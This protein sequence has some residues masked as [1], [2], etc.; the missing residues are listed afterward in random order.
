MKNKVLGQSLFQWQKDFF[1]LYFQHPKNSIFVIKSGRQ[2]AK[3]HTLQNLIM[4][5]TINNKNH[6]IIVITP[7]YNLCRKFFKDL[8]NVLEP[9]PNLVKSAN[10]SY[11]EI[12]LYN[13]STISLKSVESGNSLRGLN[14]QTLIFDEGAF[15]NLDT[16]LECFNFVNVSQGNI[17]I[18]STPKFRDENTDL[19]AKYWCMAERGEKNVYS[20]DFTTY[21]TR[22]LLSDERKEMYRKQLPKNIYLNE[23]EGQFL[24]N[25][26]ELFNLENVL[27]NGA[28]PDNNM[29]MGVDWS[30]GTNND[31]TAISIFNSSKQMVALHTFNDKDANATIQYIINILK[32]GNI[33]KCI[34][35]TNSI[36]KPMLDFLRKQ[37]SL[38]HIRV[39]IIEFQTTNSSKREIMEQLILEVQNRTITLLENFQLKNE[40]MTLVQKRTPSGLVTYSAIDGYHDDIP[41]SVCLALY[42]FKQGNYCI[43]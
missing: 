7:T 12:T 32:E 34:V 24:S 1:D 4:Y 20:I 2:R 28:I 27:F 8:S 38:N 3:T 26:S 18:S 16:A 23:I 5:E 37:I 21:D 31:N 36:G 17:V 40:F 43:R 30:S 41:M 15:I 35:E 14:C 42:G 6:D 22:A 10:S 9:I 33:K 29:I 13:K 39:Q 19:F 25:E 11:L